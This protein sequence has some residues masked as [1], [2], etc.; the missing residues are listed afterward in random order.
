MKIRNFAIIA[1]I[2]HG[3]STLADRLLEFTNTVPKDKLFPQYLDRLS[4]EREKGIT[5]KMQPVTMEY[6]GHIFNLIDT[7]G[8]VDFSYEV[9]RALAAVEGVIL[10]VDGTQGIQAQT[11]SNCDLAKSQN[12]KIIP[13]I[14]KID[15]EIKNLEDLI[16]ELYN[17]TGEEKI[18]LI[19]AKTG[20]GVEELIDGIIKKIPSPKTENS[21]Y[22]RALVFDSHFDTYKGIVAHVRVFNGEFRKNQDAYLKQK[23]FKF[24]ILEV[25]LFKPELQ[26][27]EFLGEGMIGYIATGIKDPGILRIGETIVLEPKTPALAGYEEPTPNVFAN[28]FPNEEGKYEAFR[29]NI[30]KLHLND[31]AIHLEQCFDYTLGRGFTIGAL[32]LLHLEIFEERLKREFGTEIFITLPSVK[33]IVKL[34]DHKLKEVRNVQEFPDSNLIEEI[35]EPIADVEIYTPSN[36]LEEISI[37]IKNHRGQIVDINYEQSILKIKAEIPLE[38]IIFGFFDD[39]KSVSSGYAS[40][41]WKFSR[42]AKGNLVKLDILIA[43][44]KES[45]LSRIIP[46]DK[47]EKIGRKILLK[48]K[49][50]LPRQEF[51]IKL[52]AA[53]NKRVIARETIPAI[54]RDLA[55]WLYGGDRT[56]KM[57]IWQKQK[58]G[59]KK[60]EK[61]FRG[62]IKLPN[63]V[64]REIIKLK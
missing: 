64:L 14:N 34:K 55:G 51:P 31:P 36:F 5:I 15:L 50:L 19:S 58:K 21:N 49:E 60:L 59:K 13:A 48:L 22:S 1:H 53:I 24:K 6:S 8:H 27:R 12:L 26:E 23:N 57:K 42:Y 41:K 16:L 61:I 54:Y 63:E 2:D 10:L 18:Y 44:E 9:S 46:L 30:L 32:G 28:I 11:V 45:S 52:Q 43:E 3:K 38:E 56:R 33:Y 4:L 17:L 39:L 25:G 29:E 40:L 37:L 62:K 20:Q 35:W 47:A 7:P